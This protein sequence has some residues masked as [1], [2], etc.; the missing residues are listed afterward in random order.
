MRMNRQG[1]SLIE[2]VLYIGL[3]AVLIPSFMVMI[4]GFV[5]KSDVVD[6]TIRMEAMTAS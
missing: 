1:F 3:L 4:F 2:T 6:L 5:Q